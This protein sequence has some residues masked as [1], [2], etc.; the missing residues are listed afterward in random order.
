[1][2]TLKNL[3]ITKKISFTV[4]G[5][6]CCTLTSYLVIFFLNNDAKVN[7]RIIDD[8]E[9]L[10][11]ML[12]ESIKLAMAEGAEDTTPFVQSFEKFNK[13]KDVRI[14]PTAII[15]EKSVLDLDEFEKQAV[16]NNEES[17]YFE[18]F[19][20]SQVLRS[21]KFLRSD[22]S[23]SDCHDVEKGEILAVIS[24]RQ[25]LDA[26]Y[27]EMAS[28]KIDAAWIGLLAAIIT[29]TLVAY[30]V[31]RNL[32]KPIEQLTNA[33]Q[34][35][36][37][38][39]FEKIK[40]K[41]KDELGVLANSFNNMTKQ[42]K[43]Q[44]QY[45]ENLPTPIMVVDNDFNIKYMNK[46]GAEV[47]GQEQQ[48][49]KG[50]KCYDHFKTED[51]NKDKC[52]CLQSMKRDQIVIEETIAR[53]NG[54]KFPIMY[55]GA[56][57]KDENGNIIGAIGYV[58]DISELKNR[59]DYLKRSTKIMMNAMKRFSQGDLSV[60]VT[61]EIAEDEL[62]Q[63]FQSFNNTVNNIKEMVGHLNDA[64]AAT[65]SASTEISASAEEMATGSQEQSAQTAE[66]ATAIEQIVGTIKQT[67]TNANEAT[68]VVGEAL[69]IVE[70]LGS[71]SKEIGKITQV[72]NDISDQT[73]LLALNAAIEA[74]R[75]GEYGRGF[76]VVADEVR[77]LAER[78]SQAT[79]E[80]RLMIDQMQGYTEQA[81][82]VMKKSDKDKAKHKVTG[83]KKKVSVMDVVADVANSSVELS[84]GADQIKSSINIINNV[85]QESSLGIQQMAVATEDLY[86]LTNNL[87]EIIGQF[88]VE[89]AENYTAEH[90]NETE[91]AKLI[92]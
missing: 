46:K 33:V 31:N 73:N 29:F 59:E 62:G 21:I 56:P 17:N 68:T 38:G 88:N 87:S 71:S 40:V 28:Q 91:S 7:Q 18:E 72:I 14:T 60:S 78:T 35:F 23:C 1:M 22:N 51:C 34:N 77:K 49:L 47:V 9:Q 48:S 30:F 27:S 11:L 6:L 90:Y 63:L 43:M 66:V 84:N 2:E 32:G 76:A 3:S 36:S 26:T 55:T 61:P 13:I 16:N 70:D 8:N 10:S 12:N 64:I 50:K 42:I 5:I 53:P 39:N 19:E 54:A 41:S 25:S 81:V 80:I 15:D 45:L 75:A 86:N 83:Q 79:K 37:K 4:F 82:D 44:I 74:A 58:T 85:T 89:D 69:K 57:I 67:S 65:A 20:K 24:I 92:T 52:A